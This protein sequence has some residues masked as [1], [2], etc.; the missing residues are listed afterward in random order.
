LQIS[1]QAASPET[2]GYTLVYMNVLRSEVL[3]IKIMIIGAGW[4]GR[5]HQ[6][7]D[8]CTVSEHTQSTQFPP[9]PL[10]ISRGQT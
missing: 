2:F 3:R 9:R 1:L 4:K 6:K 7:D 10:Q 5:E 8:Q